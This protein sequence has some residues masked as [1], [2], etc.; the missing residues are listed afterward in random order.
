MDAAAH[1][2][3]VYTQKGAEQVS[4][5]RSHLETSRAW[6]E[7]AAPGRTAAIIDIGGGAS[8]LVDDLLERGYAQLTVLDVSAHAL[9]LARQRLGAHAGSVHWVAADVTGTELPK[10]AYDVWHD[11]AVFHFLTTPAARAAYARQAAR[12]LRP[13]GHLI[14]STF[15]PDGPTRCSGLDAMRYSAET[16]ATALGE[17]FE[18]L[19]STVE[20]HT[21]PA[22]ASQ[23][24]V[25][26]DL[27]QLP[28]AS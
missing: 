23:Q 22:G 4:W 10:A 19:A 18:L 2:E 26:C 1:W 14:V 13:S 24:F 11:R 7:R 15:G 8:T 5:Y 12:A 21:T 3:Q 16:L 25:V 9:E 6:I 28:T 17:R 20:V 27:L